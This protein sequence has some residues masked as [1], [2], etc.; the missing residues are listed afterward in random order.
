[1]LLLPAVSLRQ[2]LIQVTDGGCGQFKQNQLYNAKDV[3]VQ[4][5]DAGDPLFQKNK[6]GLT[7]GTGVLVKNSSSAL[8]DSN[9]LLRS[10]KGACSGVLQGRG[11]SALYQRRLAVTRWQ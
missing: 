4:L 9:T 3:A 7:L 8:L 10:R 2:I 1:M 11:G 6:I 5:E